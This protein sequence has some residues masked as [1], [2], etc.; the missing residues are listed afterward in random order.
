MAMTIGVDRTDFVEK[1]LVVYFANC[2][3]TSTFAVSQNNEI[4]QFFYIKVVRQLSVFLLFV[5]V[6]SVGAIKAQSTVIH[7]YEDVCQEDAGTSRTYMDTLF[8]ENFDNPNNTS[9]WTRSTGT[10][11]DGFQFVN[12]IRWWFD[13]AGIVKAYGNRGYSAFER[14]NRVRSYYENCT[15]RTSSLTTPPIDIV[16][17][18]MTTIAFYVYD[19]QTENVIWDYMGNF[20]TNE[21]EGAY[22][23]ESINDEVELSVVDN[24]T[25]A[26]TS[27]WIINNGSQINDI[28]D[29]TPTSYQLSGVSAG[30]KKFTFRHVNEG[31]VGL[32]IDEVLVYGPRKVT[33]PASVATAANGTEVTTEETYYRIGCTQTRVITHWRVSTCSITPGG[34]VHMVHR[35][36]AICEGETG[37]QASW[38]VIDDTLLYETFDNGLPSCWKTYR[39][40]NCNGFQA[41]T[42]M[43]IRSV[44]NTSPIPPI[45]PY[46]GNGSL[47][48]ADR[49][50]NNGS[51]ALSEVVTPLV[52]IIDPANT[53]ISYYVTVPGLAYQNVP[54]YDA[55]QV[56]VSTS[57]AYQS[58]DR[59]MWFVDAGGYGSWQN[60]S[61][62]LGVLGS[63]S[64]Y[65]HFQ[66][67]NRG[68]A[69]MGIDEVLIKGPRRIN[70]PLSVA[71]ARAGT[72]GLVT[73]DTLL[74]GDCMR[75]TATHW[76]I[77]DCS[78][79]QSNNIPEFDIT[80]CAGQSGYVVTETSDTL[81]YEDFENAS[82]CWGA[83]SNPATNGL[84][85]NSRLTRRNI[86]DEYNCNLNLD[87]TGIPNYLLPDATRGGNMALFEAA[88]RFMSNTDTYNP[89]SQIV[90]P[91]IEII[92][93]ASTS[94]SFLAMSNGLMLP[95]Y[96]D[97]YGSWGQVT[98]YQAVYDEIAVGY[99][100]AFNDSYNGLL[101]DL[102]GGGY[103]N[104]REV[105]GL[106]SVLT[107]GTHYFHFL[108]VN[109]GGYGIGFDNLLIYGPRKIDIPVE[110]SNM[111]GGHGGDT[112]T[113]VDLPLR[114]GCNAAQIKV[115]WHVL[116]GEDVTIDSVSCLP[117]EWQGRTYDSSFVASAPYY[118]AGGNCES[119]ITMRFTRHF[120]NETYIIDT[121]CDDETYYFAGTVL[122]HSGDFTA[123]LRNIYL[124]D[125]TV[126]LNLSY[127]PAYHFPQMVDT[128]DYENL[129]Y[130][131][132]YAITGENYSYELHNELIRFTA[133]GGCDSNYQLTLIIRYNLSE[134][135]TGLQF[136]N[137]ITPNG[138]NHNDRFYIVGLENGCWPENE[139]II[140]NRWGGRVFSAKNIKSGMDCW[141]PR[142]MPAGTYFYR[143]Q[144][145][146]FRGTTER[147]GAVEVMK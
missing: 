61:S 136:P 67:Q 73:Y 59:T 135:D 4:M 77:N 13:P 68:G 64:Y 100:S 139:L 113:I 72:T 137:V 21:W 27:L 121:A 12:Q 32:G 53:T 14:D 2:V 107:A 52:D 91:G 87:L 110:V 102:Q 10:G 120:P 62:T 44:P 48:E 19:E 144:A 7:R 22:G 134:C 51:N 79:P 75:I 41:S 54:Y 108:H 6:V 127:F 17:P 28:Y 70:I 97:C 133:L 140:Y 104:W 76:T 42:R 115:N 25:G 3:K 56:A 80:I 116:S 1:R 92:D 43:T 39:G 26:S 90:S 138:D 45:N 33:V 74:S 5:A 98:S 143:F 69:G 35:N 145:R 131:G 88:R 9:C 95:E 84:R 34:D 63:G 101:W 109:K 37:G 8:Y 15:P 112:S 81:F 103:G 11:C 18:S 146:N 126:H 105:S 94:I 147:F 124:C 118:P 111:N 57:D 16:D 125:S 55:A 31:G 122:D 20:T 78:T 119:I 36:D 128:V 24:G 60:V 96:Y 86:V 142:F 117:I 89:I 65:F 99:G 46:R 85:R 38:K 66:H 58:I 49:D 123:R 130:T 141:E 23:P 114:I 71:T 40:T 106:L 50:F 82:S 30:Q 93:P 83:P 47:F 29:W 129:P 132:Y